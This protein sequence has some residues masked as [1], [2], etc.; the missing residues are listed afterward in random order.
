M[1]EEEFKQFEALCAYFKHVFAVAQQRFFDKANVINSLPQKREVEDEFM[2]PLVAMLEKM[3]LSYEQAIRDRYARYH[4]DGLR[5][6]LA[7]NRVGLLFPVYLFSVLR[8]NGFI[9]LA[10]VDTPG[11]KLED[12]MTNETK[13][14]PVML[15]Y[16][17]AK[18]PGV[19]D[20]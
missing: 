13:I 5:S 19:T 15:N 10:R 1:V 20:V 11:F 8:L 7:P 18:I 9:Y 2:P 16:A 12:A 14:L 4:E 17:A 6:A 3:M